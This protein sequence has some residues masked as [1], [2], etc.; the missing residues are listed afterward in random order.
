MTHTYS[1]QQIHDEREATTSNK[2]LS[3]FHQEIT[4]S[5]VQSVLTEEAVELME[6]EL[7]L[8]HKRELHARLQKQYMET[9]DNNASLASVWDASE[10]FAFWLE[11]PDLK[12]KP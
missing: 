9:L 11:A 10:D 12:K 1:N 3:S 7:S 2:V 5:A 4:C 8:I 6:H